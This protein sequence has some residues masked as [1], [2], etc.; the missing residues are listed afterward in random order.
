MA[1]ALTHCRREVVEG[2]HHRRI[3]GRSSRAKI[4]IGIVLVVKQQKKKLLSVAVSI[5]VVDEADNVRKRVDLMGVGG[6][7][8]G[9][10]GQ[11]HGATDSPVGR[12]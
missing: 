2:C 3:V 8:R 5:R 9:H 11:S 6:V 1:D 7:H 10:H 12:Y 4:L